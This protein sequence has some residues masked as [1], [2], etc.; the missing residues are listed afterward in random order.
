MIL[1]AEAELDEFLRDFETGAFPASRWDHRAHLAMAA[2]YLTRMTPAAALPFLRE[3]IKAY[4]ES[5]GGRNTETSGYHESLTVFWIG[6][7]ARHLEGLDPRLSR[8]E[9]TRSV[10]ETFGAQ[11]GLFRAYWSFDV[12]ASVEARAKWIPPDAAPWPAG[13]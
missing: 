1:E 4:N 8:V 11:R 7:V 9:K 6:I 12:V 2:G 3:R 10:V 13:V 5:Q